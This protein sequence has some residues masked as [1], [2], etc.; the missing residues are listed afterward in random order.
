VAEVRLAAAA[1]ADLEDAITYYEAIHPGLGHEF[2]TS[3]EAVIDGI[4]RRPRLAT[5]IE[6]HLLW[7]RLH[8]FPYKAVYR[9]HEDRNLVVVLGVFHHRRDPKIWRQRG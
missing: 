5:L 3:F 4:E 2:L 6:E 9:F 1:Y 7:V 8:R